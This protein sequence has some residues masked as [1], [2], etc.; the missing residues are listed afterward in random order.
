MAQ[1]LHPAL[2][3]ANLEKL[4]I[5]SE[6]FAVQIANNMATYDGSA[7]PEEEARKIFLSNPPAVLA[8]EYE[9]RNFLG[10]TTP[11]YL[12]IGDYVLFSP[13]YQAYFS[14]HSGWVYSRIEASGFTSLKAAKRFLTDNAKETHDAQVQYMPRN[15]TDPT[16]RF[17]AA[18]KR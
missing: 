15:H 12:M 13:D 9:T 4:I 17:M 5:L 18:H 14:I 1:A 16:P 11:F 3:G 7:W 2:D 10:K 6:R 8:L